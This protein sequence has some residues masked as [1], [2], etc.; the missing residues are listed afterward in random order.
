MKK[1]SLLFCAFTV[2]SLALFN[3][4]EVRANFVPGAFNTPTAWTQNTP[5]ST[6][7][8]P[9]G[10]KKYTAQASTD[11]EFKLTMLNTDWN[12]GWGSG[13]WINA[14]NQ[15]WSLPYVATGLANAFVKAFGTNQFMTVVTSTNL[16]AVQSTFGFLKTSASP[17]NVSAVSGGITSVDTN[18]S[19][20]IT[21][22]L[23]ASKCVEEFILIRYT[24]DNWVTSGFVTATGSETSYSATIPG[25]TVDNSTVKW[26][27]LT[28]TLAAPTP[29]TDFLTLSVMN[30][31]GSN[32]SYFT[33][34]GLSIATDHFRS[35]ATG[36][37]NTPGSWES[38]AGGNINNWV[39]A[40]LVPGNTATAIEIL[41]T[42]IITIDNSVT[43]NTALSGAGT[44][45]NSTTGTLNLTGG[46]SSVSTLANA[47]TVAISG[48]ATSTT[49]L[50]NFTN[51]GA[52]NISGSGTITGIT[53]N[54]AGTVNHSGSSTVTSFNNA[55]ATS[56]L[57]ISTTTVPTFTTLTVSAAGNTVNYTGAGAQTVKDVVYGGNL[58]LSG[59]GTKTWTLAAARTVGGILTVGSGAGLT[60]AGNFTLGVTGVTNITGT[61]TLGGTSAK[62]FTGDVTL[63]SGGVWNETGVA[64][65][66]F[67]GN[68]T[69]NATT[70][71]SNTGIHTFSGATKTMS[72]ATTTSIGSVTVTGTYTNSGILTVATALGGTGTLTNSATGTLNLGGT[73][74]VTT[75]TASAAGNTVNYTGAAQ[76]VKVVAYSNLTLSG[77]GI[78][79][80][81][82]TSVTNDLTLAGTATVT[83][84]AALTVGRDLLLNGGTFTT[85][86]FTL[87][88][89]RN[90]V[91]N[92]GNLTTTGAFAATVTG[93][94]TITTGTLNVP[95]SAGDKTFTGLVTLNGGTMT[96]ASTTV[97]LGGGG[98]ANAGGIVTLTGTVTMSTAATLSGANNIGFGTLTVTTV[99]VT[100]NGTLT[101]ATAL[102]GT[103]TLTNSATGT[104]NLGGTSAVTTLT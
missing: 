80:C 72:G 36:I 30:N 34:T 67:A 17:I 89:T 41:S 49:A 2:Y 99:V 100:N 4:I 42:H 73:S 44:L 60:T 8:M 27:A 15:T 75:L 25:I 74:A 90:L 92:G 9:A 29:S 63:N 35:K 77:S 20:A 102:G 55:T 66:N 31:A 5:Y 101:V 54:A 61:L 24:I 32:Y 12:A 62:T 10:F 95:V 47:G 11:Q 69:N 81:A 50:A 65:I 37:W 97:V 96:G 64:A 51:T 59:T 71:T 93:T 39:T 26:Y 58:T 19:V 103:G 84:G 1:I 40:T 21:I 14:F 48:T 22:T 3:S 43:V 88:V 28:S 6:T 87:A 91:L 68:L 56:T 13:Y 82:V 86:A 98:F 53:N 46:T 7:N 79:T 57:N 94:T 38:S 76:T 45:T 52:I 18:T 70:F 83:H 104:L 78:K 85:G 16:T 23:S 33:G